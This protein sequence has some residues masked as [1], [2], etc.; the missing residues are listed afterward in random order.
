M[1][2]QRTQRIEL[3]VLLCVLNFERRYHVVV[4]AGL[5]LLGWLVLDVEVVMLFISNVGVGASWDIQP[6]LPGGRFVDANDD[7]AV[8]GAVD[9]VLALGLVF[10][11]GRVFQ[12]VAEL[13]ELEGL[14]V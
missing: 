10:H 12:V 8:F 4:D 1:V 13:L 14:D 3:A 5:L 7:F 9:S 11:S 2:I 6:T